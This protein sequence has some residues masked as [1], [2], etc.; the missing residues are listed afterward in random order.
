MTAKNKKEPLLQ[1]PSTE[2][3]EIVSLYVHDHLWYDH[4]G[5]RSPIEDSR[6][7]D[8]SL[9]STWSQDKQRQLKNSY[10]YKQ[11]SV[12]DVNHFEDDG[13]PSWSCLPE[14]Q[15]PMILLTTPIWLSVSMLCDLFE[16]SR[17]LFKGQRAVANG[18]SL[19]L[20][21]G[22]ITM[23][24]FAMAAFAA[25]NPVGWC[26]VLGMVSVI[27]VASLI[28]LTRVALMKE[29][30]NQSHRSCLPSDSR[31]TLLTKPEEQLIR[32][33]GYDVTEI[34]D[35][36]KLMTA[37]AWNKRQFGLFGTKDNYQT[38]IDSVV[39]LRSGN[40]SPKL[41]T[42]LSLSYSPTSNVIPNE[43]GNEHKALGKP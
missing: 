17:E 34:N 32:E 13:I 42:A 24:A 1:T 6:I 18:V 35:R 11:L 36:I 27:G 30:A 8:K 10:V 39:E 43:V 7:Y 4:V 37:R 28:K 25:S 15:G 40:I 29:D 2:L 20:S 12:E 5:V 41:K 16:M 26:V 21:A 22:Y 38:L 19:V 9:T 23:A 33:K 14:L 31:F 3:L